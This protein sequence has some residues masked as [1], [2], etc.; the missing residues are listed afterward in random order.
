M[1]EIKVNASFILPGS[2]LPAEPPMLK[3]GKKRKKRGK[4]EEEK[5]EQVSYYQEIIRLP[6]D[7]PIVISL[8]KAKDVTQNMHL[9]KEAYS[10]MTAQ[11]N[12]AKSCSKY[13]WAR[14]SKRK[15][16]EAH[17]NIIA[18]SIGGKLVDFVVLED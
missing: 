8:R 11:E 7:K 6:K 13:E 9:T 4:K 10:Y 16:L 18:E 15:R 1:S 2:V 14:M 12:P 3:N 17:L 5:E